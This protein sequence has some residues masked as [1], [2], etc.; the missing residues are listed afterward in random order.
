MGHAFDPVSDDLGM[1][2]DIGEWI[3]DAGDQHLISFQR[4]FGKATEF[5]RV[6]RAG[7]WQKQSANLRLQYGWQYLFKRHVTIMRRL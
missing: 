1:L 3:D 7:K 5:M 2:H 4:R 6:T